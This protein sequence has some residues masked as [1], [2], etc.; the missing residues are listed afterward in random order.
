MN[1]LIVIHVPWVIAV[2]LLVRPGS[3]ET[4]KVRPLIQQGQTAAIRT[5]TEWPRLAPE[6]EEFSVMTPAP[7]SVM[8]Q[9]GNYSFE[10]G[11]EKVLEHQTYGGY[12]DGFVFVIESYRASRPQKIFKPIVNYASAR[13]SFERDVMID[14]YLGKEYRGDASFYMSRIL[15]LVAKQHVYVLRLAAR[16]EKNT[17]PGRFLDSF[18]LGDQSVA[19]T[20]GA[21]S[22]LPPSAPAAAME[23]F[24]SKE[25]THK[26]VVVWKPE[27]AYTQQ[28]RQHQLTGMIVLKAIFAADGQ[29]TNIEVLKG[30]KD[31]LTEKAIEAARNVRFF[32]AEKD[33]RLVSQQLMLEYNFNLY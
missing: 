31:G 15:C 5:D 26:V 20:P 29:V 11:G 24:R 25:V 32:P 22:Q 8:T 1:R 30:L 16:D 4:G 7:L 18:K 10:V 14:G 23:V 13:A 33:G 27:P 21:T 6:R 9:R 28:A 2:L 19:R 3:S 12:A 17:F